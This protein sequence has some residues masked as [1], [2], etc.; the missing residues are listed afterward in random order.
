MNCGLRKLAVAIALLGLQTLSASAQPW[1][2]DADRE[3][4]GCQIRLYIDE[5]GTTTASADIILEEPVDLVPARVEEAL[6][7]ALRPALA[8][9][10][11]TKIRT[12][13]MVRGRAERAFPPDSGRIEGTLDPGALGRLVRPLGI[14]T[15]EVCVIWSPTY[16]D[17]RGPSRGQMQF[18]TVAT[19]SPEPIKFGLQIGATGWARLAT[20]RRLVYRTYCRGVMETLDRVAGRESGAG[21][22]LVSVLALDPVDYLGNMADLADGHPRR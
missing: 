9:V 14:E 4:T 20:S 12:M 17:R 1:D 19:S 18:Y 13:V 11:R 6:C 7:Q 21:R 16:P 22:A 10:A 5:Y 8:D 3:A 2:D 15:I